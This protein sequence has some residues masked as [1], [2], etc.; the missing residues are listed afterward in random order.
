VAPTEDPADGREEPVADDTPV[1]RRGRV[2]RFS[3]LSG[4]A[5]VVGG[6]VLIWTVDESPGL[7]WSLLVVGLAWLATVT[8]RRDGRQHAAT[9]GRRARRPDLPRPRGR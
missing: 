8:G 9:S 6:V 1:E 4:L 5:L 7:G 3:L 2:Q